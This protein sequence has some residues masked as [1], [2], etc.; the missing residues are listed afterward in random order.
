MNVDLLPSMPGWVDFGRGDDNM[1]LSETTFKGLET[2]NN[3]QTPVSPP[4]IQLLK[5][6]PSRKEHPAWLEH[7]KMLL[8]HEERLKSVLS[9]GCVDSD[10]AAKMFEKI[11]KLPEIVVC[12]FGD[13]PVG[14]TR[15]SGPCCNHVGS[16]APSPF[17][18]CSLCRC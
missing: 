6:R 18:L 12:G 11:Q 16:Q 10:V 3:C 13:H 14:D 2:C 9:A 1:S 4:L 5:E 8:D 15:G 7:Q 17:A